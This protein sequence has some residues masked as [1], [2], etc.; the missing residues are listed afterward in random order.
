[1]KREISK[2]AAVRKK[3]DDKNLKI[4]REIV[5]LGGNRQ[6]FDCGQRGPTYVNMTIGSF[7]CTRCSGM[8][9]GITPP[10]RVKSISMATFTPDEID[11]IRSHGNDECA[12]TWL[13][14]W[15]PK[16]TR[17][18]DQRELMI[19]KYERKRYYLEP[20]SP[21]KSLAS[22]Q[23]LTPS[24][25]TTTSV[26]T[27]TNSVTLD[28]TAVLKSITLTP[29]Q[30]L[31]LHNNKS[32][33]STTKGTVNFQHQF[34]PDSETSLFNLGNS[35]T[36]LNNNNNNSVGGHQNGLTSDTTSSSNLSG[37]VANNNNHKFTPDTDFVADFGSATIFNATSS[38]TM[39]NT[40][41][42]S[43]GKIAN[44]TNNPSSASSGQQQVNGN[45]G[46]NENFADF[47]H[48][49]I[50]NSAGLPMSLSSS[51]SLNSSSGGF[52]SNSSLNS[53]PSADRYAALK[54][55]DEQLR[56]AKER[57][58]PANFMGGSPNPF[59]NPFQASGGGAQWAQSEGVFSGTT[60]PLG[61]AFATTNGFT[62]GYAKPTEAPPQFNNGA[63]SFSFNPFATTST[64][65]TNPFL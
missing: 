31:R 43:P 14:L 9:R 61:A 54:D 28:N 23:Q 35:Q 41:A 34:T 62:N 3:T 44:G 29:P 59:K 40:T 46:V 26:A 12:K 8:L 20:A 50:Y 21:L 6:C 39:V 32:A 38:A 42:K 25:T 10:H 49:T 56:D 27:T 30:S 24:A 65:S 33:R 51:T 63:G 57:E 5:S 64:H 48:N 18:H 37:I 7:V 53:T 11:F 60:P 13:G 1:M 16:R 45:G 22:S 36:R 2:M 55:L 19:D 52:A 47:E 4:L 58:V 15:D 17:P